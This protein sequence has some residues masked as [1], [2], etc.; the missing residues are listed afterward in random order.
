MKRACSSR[1]M[2]CRRHTKALNRPTAIAC[3]PDL[4]PI[5][6]A[7]SRGG[8]VAHFPARRELGP[9]VPKLLACH[10]RTV[11]K[12]STPTVLKL[13]RE[14]SPDACAAALIGQAN[15]D[16]RAE[17]KYLG[18]AKSEQRSGNHPPRRLLRPWEGR[19]DAQRPVFQT[20]CR[21]SPRPGPASTL[22]HTGTSTP[23][24]AL[25]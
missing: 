12:T 11:P 15:S 3:V 13:L 2:S 17:G 23:H 25:L 9:A 21:W 8:G 24:D 4:L 14:S 16:L 6:R 22:D 10:K 1:Q 18:R 20:E 19:R 5:N 7:G